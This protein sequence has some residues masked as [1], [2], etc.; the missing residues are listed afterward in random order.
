MKKS[1]IISFILLISVV[2]MTA[3]SAAD[4]TG[5][6]SQEN[7]EIIAIENTQINEIEN[8]TAGT[9][10]SFGQ[11]QSF[12]SESNMVSPKSTDSQSKNVKKTNFKNDILTA[13]NQDL[14]TDVTLNGGS[15]E[16]IQSAINTANVGDTIYLNGGTYTGS[17][18]QITVNKQINIYGGTQDDLN[19]PATLN[20]QESSR[21]FKITAPNVNI[22]SIIFTNGKEDNGGAIYWTGANGTVIYRKHC[23]QYQY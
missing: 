9:D 4:N 10:T 1:L 16:D 2:L 22:S 12:T 13:T 7:N 15:F 21:I 18:A 20:A 6:L 17:G 14:L 5:A 23:N 8:S 11:E 3:V 19:L